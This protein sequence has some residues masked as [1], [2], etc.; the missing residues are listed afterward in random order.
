VRDTFKGKVLR[1][2]AE[3]LKFANGCQA[4]KDFGHCKLWNCLVTDT[5]NP[6]GLSANNGDLY[7]AFGLLHA[8]QYPTTWKFHIQ[9]TNLKPSILIAYILQK[10]LRQTIL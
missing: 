6:I 8:G 7:W 9:K 4:R 2:S 1:L 10:K 3:E 5:F